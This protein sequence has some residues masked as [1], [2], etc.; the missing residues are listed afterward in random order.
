MKI[1]FLQYGAGGDILLATPICKKL[2]QKYPNDHITW[3]CFD[4][5]RDLIKNNP[6][7]DDYI[8]W[9]LT[10]G[11]TRTQQENQRWNEIKQY[12]YSNFDLVVAPQYWPDHTQDWNESD[13]RTLSDYM[14]QYANLG[15]IEDRTIVFQST[16]KEKLVAN[17]F[18]KKNNIS[19]LPSPC[20]Y[21]C[22]APYANS[23]GSLLSNEQY[24]HIISKLQKPTV[25]FGSAQNSLI[26][27][28]ISGLG[29]SFGVMH[30]I[31]KQSRGLIALESAP[32]ICCS[33]LKHV[34][35]VI[36][37][38]KHSFNLNKIGLTNSKIRTSNILEI[39]LEYGSIDIGSV[40]TQISD[41]LNK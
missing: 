4:I 33:N 14:E 23:V 5:Y 19:P 6:D 8:A 21:Y 37:R 38:N 31:V 40:S 34:P 15:T 12:A 30:E 11:F 16:E 29:L 26:D 7:I 22:I 10:P 9:P 13:N 36:L 2:R 3:I 39:V 1:A 25:C 18:V 41:F 35:L 27:N 24:S 20:D 17:D 28:S 32:A